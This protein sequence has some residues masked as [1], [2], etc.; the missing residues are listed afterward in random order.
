MQTRKT[1]T[2][3]ACKTK[4]KKWEENYFRTFSVKQ[5]NLAF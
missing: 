3:D 2:A 5:G 4:Q 1:I